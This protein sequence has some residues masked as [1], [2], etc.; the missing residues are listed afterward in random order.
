[1]SLTKTNKFVLAF[2]GLTVALA[3]AAVAT[4]TPAQAQT[5]EEL[6]AQIAAL[7]AQ[8]NALSG[9]ST[10]GGS[11]ISSAPV[12]PLTVGSTG[13][14]VTALQNFLIG[15]GFS[16][17]AGAT[18][19][20]GSQTQAAVTAYQQ[21]KGWS[22]PFGYYGSLT[23]GWV[24]ADLASSGGT[25]GG[26]GSMPAGCMPGYAF[27]TTTGQPCT[28]TGGSTGSTGTLQGGAGDIESVEFIS[29][30]NNEEVGE[31]AE[32]VEVAGWEVEATEGSDIQLVAITLDFDNTNAVSGSD[33][34]LDDYADEVSVRFNGEEVARVDARTFDDDNNY[35]RSVSLKS[36]AIVRA[37]DT[38]DLTV[39]LTGVNN[40]DSGNEGE[41]WN[42]GLIS[43]RFQD[44][45]G[46]II[47]YSSG[48]DM[49][50]TPDNDTT[51]DADERQ[52]SFEGFASA[53]NTELR[54]SNGDDDINDSR[55]INVD[56]NNDTDNVDFF[57]FEIEVRGDSD[58]EIKDLPIFWTA[59]G[60][61][62]V[63]HIINSAELFIGGESVGSENI[64]ISTA[65]GTTTF[66]NIDYT[67]P[68]GTTVEA[69]VRVDINDLDSNFEA[70]DTLMVE[71]G[72]IQTDSSLFDAE[73]EQGNDLADADKTGSARTDAH[74]FYAD[75]IQVSFVSQSVQEVTVDGNNNDYANLTIVFDITAF[76][77]D[78]WIPN[79]TTDMATGTT[80][81]NSAAVPAAS[82]GI[83][84]FIQTNA[85][86]VNLA[87]TS[88]SE[89]ITST[90]VE[91]T[92]AF[93]VREGDT[94]RF[95]LKVTINNAGATGNWS[96]R[97]IMS[98]INFALSDTATGASVFT[99]SLQDNFK[100]GYGYMAN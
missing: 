13:S 78:I 7:L 24:A 89:V 62:Q 65:T 97:A 28:T 75:G 30:L 36:G 60:A 61:T 18:G 57:S 40:L 38:E 80:A 22:G 54:F 44:A 63:Q 51:T 16:I 19:Y 73:D 1:M 15:K 68:A 14:Q 90:A 86:G 55:T 3:F 33:D 53:A 92:N 83:G 11:T 43:I 32:D 6:Q 47:T 52:F 10:T 72:E 29:G 64:S 4:V 91:G 37:G 71:I 100:T 84:Y 94:E 25:S 56:E 82:Q 85:A 12:A 93:E 49:E 59:T 87:S 31:G 21:S 8:I 79:V 77:D 45:Q 2:V 99:S 58:V 9:G 48:T 69:L 34:D 74:T 26:T 67:I 41:I 5:A 95:T 20:Y 42:V 70:G 98:G 50:S 35:R 39:A 17:P 76:G 96:G 88:I 23:A 46:A 81:S 27:S 66:D